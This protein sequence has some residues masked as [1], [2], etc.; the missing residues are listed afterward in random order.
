MEVI[1]KDENRAVS[2]ERLIKFFK[3]LGK[4]GPNAG[5]IDGAGWKQTEEE[6]RK[7]QAQWLESVE[8]KRRSKRKKGKN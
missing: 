3:T 6:Y 8:R 4:P 5:K 7:E 2:I 1:M